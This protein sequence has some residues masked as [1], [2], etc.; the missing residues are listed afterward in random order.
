MKRKI[1]SWDEAWRPPSLTAIRAMHDRHEFSTP[2]QLTEEILICLTTY[3]SSIDIQ[4]VL[5][6]QAQATHNLITYLIHEQGI[7]NLVANKKVD[8][9]PE[10]VEL[11]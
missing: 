6:Q 4:A 10:K 9:A 3:T 7:F 11:E 8:G 1:K 5:N 2:D